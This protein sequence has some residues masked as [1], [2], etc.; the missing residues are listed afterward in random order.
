MILA[1][2][3]AR[4]EAQAPAARAG[5]QRAPD[6]L[7]ARLRL[8]LEKLKGEIHASRS[9]RKASFSNRWSCSSREL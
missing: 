5:R 6:A 3:A 9:E 8:E 7:I 4:R 2:R 1:E